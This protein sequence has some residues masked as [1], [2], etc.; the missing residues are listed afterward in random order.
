MRREEATSEIQMRPKKGRRS[1]CEGTGLGDF[2]LLVSLQ[3]CSRSACHGFL[4]T[5][6][7][8]TLKNLAAVDLTSARH[9]AFGIRC[10]QSDLLIDHS[11][12]PRSQARI[13]LDLPMPNEWYDGYGLK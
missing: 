3:T 8:S 9:Q 2:C 1:A 6:N 5:K 4:K 7:L 10:K 12:I 13:S 11:S